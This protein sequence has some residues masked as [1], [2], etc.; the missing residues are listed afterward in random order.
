MKIMYSIVFSITDTWEAE[1]KKATEEPAKYVNCEGPHPASYKGCKKA[2]T[3]PKTNQELPKIGT[4]DLAA[5]SHKSE[6]AWK[7][8]QMQT[9]CS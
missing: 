4:K 1:C 8:Q 6:K 2:L 5:D 7:A 3:A 9:M